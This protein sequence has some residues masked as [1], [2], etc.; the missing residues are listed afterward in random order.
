M[1]I[2]ED[3]LEVGVFVKFM[4][5]ILVIMPATGAVD[6]FFIVSVSGV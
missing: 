2:L 4:E 5:A 1:S 6:M 3:L